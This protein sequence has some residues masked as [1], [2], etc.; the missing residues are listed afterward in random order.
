MAQLTAQWLTFLTKAINIVFPYKKQLLDSDIF[1]AN[2]A[3]YYGKFLL[4]IRNQV[5]V[6]DMNFFVILLIPS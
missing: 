1:A 3:S 5:W 2:F 4:H 6:S